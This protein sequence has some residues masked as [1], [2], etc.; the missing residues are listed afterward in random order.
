MHSHVIRALRAVILSVCPAIAAACNSPS[1]VDVVSNP[2]S[3]TL[4]LASLQLSVSPLR[5]EYGNTETSEYITLSNSGTSSLTWSASEGVDWLDLGTKSGTIA[6]RS[7]KTVGLKALRN[8]EAA[9][10]YSTYVSF[11]AGSAG[12]VKIP[13]SMT[14]SSTASSTASSTFSLSPAK[15]EFGSTETKAYI[16]L[17]NSGT[18]SL[19][20]TASESEDWLEPGSDSG[21]IAAK[22]SKTVGLSIRR[23]GLSAGSYS[24]YI[25][26][27]AGTAGSSKLPVS[28][29]VPAAGSDGT[30]ST[31][32][33]RDFGAK[34]DGTT[35]DSAAFKAALDALPDGGGT[36]FVPGGTYAM[37][38]VRSGPHRA[39]DLYRK[40]N[41][42]IAGDGLNSTVLKMAPA[43]YT[44]AV[45]MI[46]MQNSSDITIRNLTLDMNVSGNT[47]FTDEQSHIIRMKSSTDI[48]IEG[49]GFRNSPGDGIYLLG[50]SDGDP[51]TERVWIENCR[52]GR[53]WRNG[54]SI[55]RGV[56]QLQIRG[57]TFD[58]ISQQAISSEPSGSNAPTDILVEDNVIRH[59]DQTLSYTVALSGT[60]PSDRMK[61]L[62]FR[63]NRIENGAVYFLWI[64]GLNIEGNTISGGPQHSTLRMQDVSNATVSGNVIRGIK[65]NEAGVVQLLNEDLQLSQNVVLKNNKIDVAPGL[66]AI[67]IR[68]AAGGITIAENELSGW[69]GGYGILFANLI[70]TGTVRSGFRAIGN[71]V[72]N[73]ATGIGF[74]VRS[75][76]FS[77]VEVKSNTIDDESPATGTT[78]ILFDGTG[79]YARFADVG[80]NIFGPGITK[81]IR[82]R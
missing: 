31:V 8:G 77:N 3:T 30:G 71:V 20:W 41:V 35:D 36:V 48:R 81:P 53:S 19:S 9:G 28:M 34:G 55:Q 37:G 27:S 54:I 59:W 76:P 15:L 13:V 11:S 47:S 6:P 52:F 74:R 50:L 44:S 78:G 32:N 22:S 49:V 16:T 10:S 63:R 73:F 61:R 4:S 2:E 82:V 26:I 80:A 29:M 23:S 7:R 75:E 45:F 5:I 33:V 1:P 38:A 62:T 39:I 79:P 60:R 68:E 46:L 51:W 21:T 66:T 70:E 18:A 14:V 65:Q 24:T 58:E 25:N 56:R 43:H 40:N 42:T 17:T 67:Y 12:S 64:D 69:G 57:N 72:N